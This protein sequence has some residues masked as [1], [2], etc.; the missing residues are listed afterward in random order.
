MTTDELVEQ[1]AKHRT[2]GSAPRAELEWIAAHGSFRSLNSG[3]VLSVKGQQVAGLYII[4]SGR[5]ALFIDR[6]AG[7]DKLVEWREGD[8]AGLLPYSRLSA[9]PGDSRVLEPS[10]IVAVPREHLQA[11]T[12]ECFEVTSILVHTMVDRTRMFTSSDLQNEKMVSLGKLSAGLAHELNNPASAIKRCAALLDERLA[13]SEESARGL[14]AASPN[15][16]QIAAIDAVHASI[17]SKQNEAVRGALEQ[18]D[19]EEAIA[20]WLARHSLD[21]RCAEPLSE[22]AVTFELLDRLIAAVP[23]P[24]LTDALHWL[25]A[26]CAIRNLSAKIQS[27]AAQISTLVNAVKGFTHMDQANVAEPV[28]IG[29]GLADTVK[30]LQSKASE[31]AVAVRLEQE[32]GLPK[33]RGFAAEFNQVWS[34]LIDNALDAVAI[35]GKVEIFAGRENQSVVVRVIDNGSGVPEEIRSR[36][37]DPFFTTKPQGQGIGLGLDVARRLVRHNDGI[38]DFESRPGR[39]EFRVRLRV[40]E[41]HSV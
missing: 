18:A 30:V 23:Q 35:G 39:T 25:A 21:T 2:L 26:G 10:Q 16:S 9:S 40:A 32:A 29:A 28:D 14:A 37:F 8:V 27:S 4:L 22:T 17:A 1:L 15:A 34:N 12:R 36:I 3:D 41:A 38:L 11:M 24:A 19:R 20:D 6:G 7:P 33:V 13:I 5:L 31:K